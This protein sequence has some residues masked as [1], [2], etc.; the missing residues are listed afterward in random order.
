MDIK[1]GDIY[2]SIH[3]WILIYGP[4]IALSIVIFIAGIL[5]IR[6]LNRWVK[7][8][9][10]RKGV[11]P[12]IRYFLQNLVAIILQVMLFVICLQVAG[13][14]LTVFSAIMAGLTVAAGLALSGTLQ[15]FVSGILILFLK[16]YR[17]GDNIT[18]QNQEGTVTSIQLFYTVI[19]T[20]DNRTM[21]VPNGQLSNNVVMNLS[22]EGKR[23]LD[24]DIRLPYV[25]D[26]EEV[27]SIIGKTI[28]ASKD[29]LPEPAWRAGI[30]LFDNDRYIIT[31]N[32]WTNAHGFYDT[33]L[34]L[35][36][37]LMTNLKEAGIKFPGMQ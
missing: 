23:R 20:F 16:P 9:I 36:A 17:V 1:W 34:A 13:L 18:A 32:V 29:I 3:N 19:L 11:N 6:L 8:A 28:E 12:S 2:D 33:K 37:K 27:K 14:K 31:I 5:L 26:F 7:K 4:G 30:S 15:N 35:N 25:A 21:I 24:I 10:A 22:R